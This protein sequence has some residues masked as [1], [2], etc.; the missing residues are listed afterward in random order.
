MPDS[1]TSAI[2]PPAPR[3]AAAPGA[4]ALLEEHLY[5]GSSGDG[6]HV[7]RVPA[8][9]RASF[10]A[11]ALLALVAVGAAKAWQQF[12]DSAA[13]AAGALEAD[14]LDGSPAP[15]LLLPLRGGGQVDLAKLRGKLVLVN[16]WASWC[17]PCRQEE[18]SLDRLSH[19]IDPASVALLA[20][21]ADEG[22]E[23]VEK[24]FGQRT[25]GY[26]VAL[27]EDAKVRD[28]WGTN[29]FPETYL[30]DASGAMRFKIIGPRD[31]TSPDALALLKQLGARTKG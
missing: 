12:G 24:F 30:I 27:D 8:P 29:K 31:W 23:P 10:L 16:F 14:A 9:L 2:D 5:S 3:R 13:R 6:V 26:Q 4:L 1:E 21:S 28:V 15:A 20:V 22:W 19:L 25:P 11:F 17:G 18:P 7:W